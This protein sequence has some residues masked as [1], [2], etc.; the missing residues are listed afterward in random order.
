MTLLEFIFLS[1]LVD[2]TTNTVKKRPETPQIF[3]YNSAQPKLYTTRK[4]LCRSPYHSGTKRTIFGNLM[5]F[6]DPHFDALVF[7]LI[8]G[9]YWTVVVVVVEDQVRIKS[10]AA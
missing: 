6:S 9:A 10:F 7:N 5:H 2:G 3:A 1:F 4:N 8:K